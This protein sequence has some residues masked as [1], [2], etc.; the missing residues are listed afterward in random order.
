MT[1]SFFFEG[2]TARLT[3]V[4]HRCPQSWW[5]FSRFA[6]E[7]AAANYPRNHAAKKHPKLCLL[8]RGVLD[9][10][11]P[12]SVI[13][14]R[15]AHRV[16]RI[17]SW[18]VDI[19]GAITPV[20]LSQIFGD[21]LEQLPLPLINTAQEFGQFA[22]A[23]TFPT[24]IVGDIEPLPHHLIRGNKYSLLIVGPDAG[25]SIALKCDNRCVEFHLGHS[26]LPLWPAPPISLL[27][28][29]TRFL[30]AGITTQRLPSLM[31]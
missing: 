1:A 20:P 21:L 13:I 31:W 18:R 24:F 27:R 29:F 30:L 26:V 5:A 15:T 6:R 28:D 7:D 11:A 22:I 10:P 23:R 2:E 25:P 17:C 8:H 14:A 3:F 16:W 12:L 9:G 4:Q 19:V